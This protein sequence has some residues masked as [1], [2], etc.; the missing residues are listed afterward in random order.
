MSIAISAPPHIDTGA[1][2]NK[3]AT[4]AKADIVPDAT[5]LLC[6]A[7][8]FQTLYDMPL[9]MQTNMRRR[10]IQEHKAALGANKL[11]EQPV[12]PW[13]ADWMRWHW[14]V[15]P[16]EAWIEI[17]E[18]ATP[19]AQSYSRIIHVAS[20]PRR[21]YDGYAWLDPRNGQQIELLLRQL[22]EQ[23]GVSKKVETINL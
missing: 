12:F 13:L 14:G 8:G 6:R 15:T 4:E 3:I 9:P 19:L 20:G 10:L 5:P 17:L 18:L 1:L 2:V 16:A 7:Y 23:L 21:A 22:Y 11:F